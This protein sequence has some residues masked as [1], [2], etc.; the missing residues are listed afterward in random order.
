M[1]HAS[2]CTC[3]IVNEAYAHGWLATR[4][5]PAGIAFCL[6]F[7]FALPQLVALGRD[8]GYLTLVEVIFARYSMYEDRHW[9]AHALRCIAF[10]FLQLPILSYLA[11][12][13]GVIGLEVAA[14]TGG[15]I[16]SVAVVLVIAIVLMVSSFQTPYRYKYICGL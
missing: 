12:G 13:L 7:Q 2:A 10:V 9:P 16:S 3:R 11:S 1:S 14:L 4:W 5:I 8:R 15:A 6:A